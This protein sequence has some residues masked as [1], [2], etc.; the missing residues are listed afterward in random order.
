MKFPLPKN[1]ML[2]TAEK[3]CRATNDRDS[4][5]FLLMVHIIQAL[6]RRLCRSALGPLAVAFVR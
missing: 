2:V 3:S 4:A 6:A 5:R 1:L